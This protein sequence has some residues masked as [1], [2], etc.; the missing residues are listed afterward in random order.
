MSGLEAPHVHRRDADE[1]LKAFMSAD[2]SIFRSLV[3]YSV[4]AI[5]RLNPKC[6]ILYVSP[7]VRR[8]LGYEP[9]ELLGRIVF[10]L[11]Y[12]PDR[13]IARAAAA[14]SAEPGVENS[15]G[16]QRW[17]HKDGH[18][19]WIEVNGRMVRGEGGEPRET[20]LV[21]RDISERKALEERLEQLTLTDPLTG[22]RNRRGF[23][24][25][26]DREWKRTLRMG[27]VTSLL[28]L[29]LD[30][31]KRI[32]DSYGHSVGDDCLR[33]AACAFSGTIQRDT[34]LVARY[35]GKELAAILP[36]TDLEGAV[37]VANGVCR[38][39]AALRIPHHGQQV[40][41]SFM[42]ASIGV[43][44]ALA[45]DNVA[46]HMPGALVQAADAALY[47]AKQNGRNC[48]EAGLLVTGPGMC[49]V[50]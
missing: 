14:K 6:T 3:E 37:R 45:R 32:N 5:F 46:M 39:I 24:E 19:V 11:I 40:S 8:Q 43:A 13:L 35:G 34:D 23:D 17:V 48:V 15:P 10:D 18:L 30:H 2:D 47:K 31:F 1:V 49:R 9:E 38:A 28:L 25:S 50:A 20:I 36:H 42:T 4:D 12:E 16:T 21:T 44:T 22:L 41:G 7:A 29:D 27:S 33:A 26:L